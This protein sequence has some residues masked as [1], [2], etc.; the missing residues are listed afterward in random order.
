M[1]NERESTVTGSNGE[2]ENTRLGA[3]IDTLK[4]RSLGRGSETYRIQNAVD[5]GTIEPQVLDQRRIY[6]K[7]ASSHKEG[8]RQKRSWKDII[9]KLDDPSTDPIVAR[10][11]IRE[12][13]GDVYTFYTKRDSDH[14]V[15]IDLY[16]VSRRANLF[17]RTKGGDISVV[18]R[19][20]D[21]F[22]MPVNLIEREVTNAEGKISTKVTHITLVN[23]VDDEVALLNGAN[24]SEFIA[25]RKSPVNV[26]G[27]EMDPDEIPKTTDL[28]GS[29]KGNYPR[30]SS[31]L[32]ELGLTPFGL[33]RWGIS[34][35][36][37]VGDNP[38]IPILENG[39]RYFVKS[40]NLD[41]FREYLKDRL[42]GFGI[43]DNS[44][45]TIDKIAS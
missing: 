28:R 44:K 6:R 21:K 38:P 25:M 43:G 35:S 24:G 33:Q 42:N 32:A 36:D 17:P 41:T 9:E 27:P 10:K 20:L 30:I 22:S 14:P 23:Y 4:R 39:G 40:T 7:N 1:V 31:P 29:R 2:P 8:F 18:Y 16:S 3:P 34:L 15:F 45:R 12:I 37:L 26:L 13:P 19:Y 11:L 5:V